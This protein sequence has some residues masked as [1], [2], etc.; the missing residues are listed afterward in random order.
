MKIFSTVAIALALQFFTATFSYAQK[1]CI[2]GDY[3]TSIYLLK[4]NYDMYY[5]SGNYQDVSIIKTTCP[6][7]ANATVSYAVIKSWPGVK[8]CK[9][10][11]GDDFIWGYEVSFTRV[12]C[13][14]DDYIPLMLLAVSI[15]G[16]VWIKRG[17]L[18][19]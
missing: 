17:D 19:I 7:G 18:V 10:K 4:N 11:Y 1:G 12:P 6:D 5:I 2:Q 3:A 16:F 13:P 9:I 8:T 15:F 14:I